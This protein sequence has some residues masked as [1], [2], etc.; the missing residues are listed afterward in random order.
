MSQETP[1][2]MLGRNEGRKKN[3]LA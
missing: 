3:W 1:N 2:D